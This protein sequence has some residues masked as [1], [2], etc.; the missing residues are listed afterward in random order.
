MWTVCVDH[1]TV[2]AMG[3]KP[4]PWLPNHC[5]RHTGRRRDC[6]ACAAA[7]AAATED[8]R[9]RCDLGMTHPREPAAA[10]IPYLDAIRASYPTLDA[11]AA[12]LGVTASTITR[13]QT[14][15]TRSVTHATAE[16]IRGLYRA[17]V[18]QGRI[19]RMGMTRPNRL[20]IVDGNREVA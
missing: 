3:K 8:Y 13:I 12:A 14:G 16:A 2:L 18:R 15:R 5:R 11:T 7:H 20:H 10:Q 6:R 1:A 4:S 9:N 17:R 19:P